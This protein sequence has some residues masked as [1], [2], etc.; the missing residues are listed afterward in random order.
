VEE[1]GY[2]VASFAEEF[3]RDFAEIKKSIQ[4]Q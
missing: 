2:L 1:T 3:C 4:I